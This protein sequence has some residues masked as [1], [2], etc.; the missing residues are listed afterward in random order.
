[1]VGKKTL[2]TTMIACLCI[3]LL[4]GCGKNEHSSKNEITLWSSTTGP[5]GE[6]IQKTIDLYNATEPQYKV[7]LMCMQGDTFQAKLT[8]AGKSGKGV[9][10]LALVASEALPTYQSQGIL[11]DWNDAISGSE[12]KEANYVKSA[13]DVGTIQG[14]QYGI[15]ATMG[16]W[17][18]YYNK[19]LV[20]KY[21]PN[22]LD[23]GIITYEEI[24][25]AGEA[26]KVDGIYS[27]GYTWGMQNF[28]N[29]YLQMGGKWLNSDGKIS[30]N[31]DIAEAVVEEFKL[32]NDKG[33]MVPN[34]EDANKL[35]LNQQLIF[36]PE[37]TWMLNNML[38]IK[39]F[40]WGETF[41]PQ[42]DAQNI[43]QGSGVDQFAIFK[44]KEERSE[45]KIAGMVQFLEWL[46][47][48][49]L[50]WIKS[51][52]NPSSLEML[53]NEEYL[54]MPQSFLL[55][56]DKGRNAININ[57]TEG[58]SYVFSEYDIRSWDMILGKADIKQTL[59]EIQKIVDEKMK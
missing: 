34:G 20:D 12:L 35:F 10:D 36:L 46:Q 48:N 1:M 17:V 47:S 38:S 31:N 14:K 27:Y 22:A 51:G 52:A 33:Y 40:E 29:L 9:P 11:E 21:V 42:W 15:P 18:M 41:T 8:T 7:K 24:K 16:S 28:S 55:T 45:E 23:D 57:T 53:K 50:E 59:D 5:D 2:V 19:N 58:L 44:S 13:W 25:Q 3:G 54:K 56:T 26:A 39:E 6:R 32:L 37:G 4:A 30:I 43:V 49:Q